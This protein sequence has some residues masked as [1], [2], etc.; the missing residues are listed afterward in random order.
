M[1]T[2]LYDLTPTVLYA[3]STSY[4]TTVSLE[5]GIRVWHGLVPMIALPRITSD[6]THILGRIRVCQSPSSI[7]SERT[8]NFGVGYHYSPHHLFGA[9]EI[10]RRAI[11]ILWLASHSSNGVLDGFRR[12]RYYGLRLVSRVIPLHRLQ[13]PH[14]RLLMHLRTS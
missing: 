7:S 6:T 3:S 10:S 14:E 2:A 9:W 11:A 8:L 5:V 4:S 12:S 1:P 13:R